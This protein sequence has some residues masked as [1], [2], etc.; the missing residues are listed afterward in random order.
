MSTETDKRLS[1]SLS[2]RNGKLFIEECS[3]DEIAREFG[4]PIY[5]V[6]EH[7]LRHNYRLFKNAFKKCWPEGE[8]RILPALKANPSI[9]VRRIL[10]QEGAGCDIFG[11]G[12]LEAAIRGGVEPS[13][14]SVNGSIKAAS[15]IRRA[16]EAGARIVL[17]S[18]RELA[19]CTVEAKKLNKEARVMLRLKPHMAALE[20]KSDFLPSWSIRDLTQ[21]IKYGIPTS[22]V[23]ELARTIRSLEG[24]DLV[25]Y[26]IH[27]GRHSKD[28][29]VWKSLVTAYVEMIARLDKLMDGYVPKVVD[30][31]GGFPSP[32]DCD[33]D[34]AVKEGPIPSI[35]E[36]FA[37]IS[38]TFRNAMKNAGLST[39]GITLEVEPGRSLHNNT[40]IHVTKVCN[41]KTEKENKP[42]RW[43][44]VDTSEMFLGIGGLNLSAPPF[45]FVVANKADASPTHKSDIAGLTCN[46]EMLFHQVPV[47][48]LECGD[49]VA[50][51]N[52]GSYK[53]PCANN[54][55]ALPRPG[56]A[57][58]NGKDCSMIRRHETIED[59]FSR[60]I[61]PDRL[62]EE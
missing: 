56:M 3:V 2:I 41:T 52:T 22:E 49:L 5:I 14:I 18:P 42:W 51:L 1:E 46:A 47:P 38:E 55:N 31:G 9:A 34:V 53:E 13:K 17:D 16:I 20:T 43:A 33:T 11:P 50:F 62:L 27:M 59:V 4:T 15:V 40:A 39:D 7:Q 8:T 24:I 32:D 28:L 30:F 29:N 21:I 10:T 23:I 37:C 61:V 12:E 19:L 57:L 58:V 6:S 45:D 44:E 60:D 35:D 48:D 36:Y 25:G 54:F 26:H